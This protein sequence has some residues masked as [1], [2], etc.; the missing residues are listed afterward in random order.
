MDE[1]IAWNMNA[2][3]MGMLLTQSDCFEIFNGVTG[4]YEF[5]MSNC[6]S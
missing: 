1:A 5:L 4:G 3:V 2:H 6:E